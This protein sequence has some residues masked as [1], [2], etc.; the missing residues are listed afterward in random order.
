M[1]KKF[2]LAFVLFLS[3][4]TETYAA[5]ATVKESF[6]VK[7]SPNSIA[8][9]IMLETSAKA[10]FKASNCIILQDLENRTKKIEKHS[11]KGKFIFTVQTKLL[12]KDKLHLIYTKFVST[13][14]EVSDHYTKIFIEPNPNG[15]TD[16]RIVIY[17][18][19][20]KNNIKSNELA[21]DSK[22]TARKIRDVIENLIRR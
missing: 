12:V 8:E 11:P 1:F 3:I 19:V 18:K 4:L 6:Q 21:I 9:T 20:D 2:V 17:T 14:S 15:M 5:E 10:I 22:K 16:V 13:Q 7:G